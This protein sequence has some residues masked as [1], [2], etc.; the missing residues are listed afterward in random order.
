MTQLV[1]VKFNVEG[2]QEVSQLYFWG[3]QDNSTHCSHP[4]VLCF[5][6]D[7]IQSM[8]LQVQ[9]LDEL[10]YDVRWIEYK[11]GHPMTEERLFDIFDYF[12]EKSK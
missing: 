12:E 5:D 4:G 3:V 9:L 10:G 8:K 2:Y 6:T 11:D 7:P 1:G